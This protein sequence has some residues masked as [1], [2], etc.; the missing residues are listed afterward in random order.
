M[1]REKQ[2]LESKPISKS[3]YK[4]PD[5][6]VSKRVKDLLSQMTLEEKAAQ[7][8]CV[9][10]EK[11]KTLVDEEGNFD[12]K[13]AKAAY[14]KG[15]GLG[16]VGRPSDAGKG[17]NAR[18]MAELTNEIQKFFIENSR[19]GIPVIFHEECLHGHAGIDGTSFPQPIALGATFN[20]ELIEELFKMTAEEV[21]LRGT[22]QALTPVVD[23][24][25]DPRWGRVEETYGEDPYLV[26]RLGIAAVR[27]FQGDATFK[28][29]KRVIATLKHF[30][31]H[32]QPESGMNCAPANVS[33]RVLRE[34]FLYT[35]KEAFDKAGAISVMA[36]YNEVDGEPSHASKWLL[37][38]VLRKEWGFK[39]FVVSDYYAIW[40]LGYRPDTHGHFVA[41]DKK[42][43]CRLA[44][45]AGVNIELPEPDCYLHLVELV[46]KG[47]LEEKQLDELV[48]PMLYWKFQMGLFDDPYV[49]P[50]EA[51]RVVGSEENRKLA[52]RAAREA[53]TLL[54]NENDLLPLN[55]KKL[56][57]IAVIGP[58]AN[59]SLLGGYSG[60]PKHDV[61]VLEGIRA[62]VGDRV[63]VLY[64]EGCKITLGGAWNQDE[65]F[66]SDAEEDRR[67]IKE[68]VKLAKKAD[69]IILA[70]GGNEQTSREAW[71][72]N[73]MGDRT[74][75]DL[76][77]RQDELVK[78]M[79]AL[80]KP[81]VVFLFNG[82]PNSINYVSENVPA[83]FECFYLGQETGHAV[84]DVL[85]GDFNP[86]GKLPITIPRSAG[87]IPAFYNYKPSARRGYLFD[88]VTPLYAFGYGLSYTTFKIENARLTK[89]K[90]KRD[91][92]TSL[93]AD[94]TNTGKRAGT[95]TVQMYIRDLVS[96]V[97]RPVKELKGFVK[98]SLKSG[99]TK[100]VEIEIRPGSLSF[101][102][103]NMKYVV[104]AGEFE[105]MVGNSS[106]D[107]DL[108]KVVLKVEN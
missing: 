73:H 40:E 38:D 66:A 108:Q 102:D 77:G 50:A 61:S 55:V 48:A 10:Q 64:S 65:V 33:M 52:L 41:K 54:K 18:G 94:V 27:G 63:K 100:T 34:T 98:L 80:D 42:E 4:N 67:Q 30:V 11:A 1:K 5:L 46:R 103:V 92:S 72:L 13:K 35:F 78:A 31:A 22:H 43:S 96:S 85:F 101:Y 25:R 53:I 71:N 88:D 3:S 99:E 97:T 28:D 69:V 68:A 6:P 37:R 81:V 75:L 90:I 76:I 47:A 105:I 15:Y 74:S 95:E 59:R 60:V 44:V 86:G 84:A 79:L 62:K 20:P 14:K 26:S 93:L 23:V 36:S 9:W 82:R 91:G 8:M 56:K 51:E 24:A 58:N 83:I 89:K 70:I 87:H 29:K 7:M 106:R 16:Q 21:R 19:L 49:D 104:E 57:T 12:I 17:K 107:V 39:G 45:E 2:S 32:G